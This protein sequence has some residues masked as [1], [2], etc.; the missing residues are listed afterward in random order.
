MKIDQLEI[1]EIYFKKTAIAETELP[2]ELITISQG[3]G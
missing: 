1:D 3:K 2:Q